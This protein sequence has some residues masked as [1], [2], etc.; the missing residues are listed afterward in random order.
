MKNNAFVFALF[1][2]VSC[3]SGCGTK[4]RTL[5]VVDFTKADSVIDLNFSTLAGGPQV[6]PL[7]TSDEVMLSDGTRFWV[8]E[9]Y[10]VAFAPEA[11][12]QF[13]RAGKYVRKLAVQGKG[14]DEFQTVTAYTV[15]EEKD[16]LYYNPHVLDQI[17]VVNLAD[18][19]IIERIKTGYGNLVSMIL[20]EDGELLCSPMQYGPAKYL[21]YALNGDGQF[22]Y[23][24]RPDTIGQ[25]LPRRMITV[26]LG[27]FAGGTICKDQVSDT[28]FRIESGE[29]TPLCFMKVENPLYGDR[30]EG[31]V[32]RVQCASGPNL[33]VDVAGMKIV[34]TGEITGIMMTSRDAHKYYWLD[35]QRGSA[36]NVKRLYI[37]PWDS[38]VER[39][40]KLGNSGKN[41]FV[42]FAALE[43][44]NKVVQKR[45]AGETVTEQLENIDR[46]LKEDDNQV[47]VVWTIK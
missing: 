11:I 36:Q 26:F 35:H 37:A 8:G 22:L 3:F 10:I 29:K 18:G 21:V 30:P 38:Y 47:L 2:F 1:L 42:S 20:N 17:M 40:Y 16:Y 14:P 32:V 34:R 9:K 43:V 12:Y 5:P 23:G 4:E 33:F 25:E 46:H 7:E 39:L 13:D 19:S 44:K 45:E 28:L 15:D 24:I 41:F 31:N 27:T 6:I